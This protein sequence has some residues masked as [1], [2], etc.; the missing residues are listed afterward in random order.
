MVGEEAQRV[1]NL[2]LQDDSVCG[3][4]RFGNVNL[5]LDVLALAALLEF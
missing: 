5:E 3:I 1:E 2:V 4:V